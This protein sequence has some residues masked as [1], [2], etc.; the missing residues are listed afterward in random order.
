MADLT[1]YRIHD[2]ELSIRTA[3][4]LTNAFGPN[5][6]LHHIA[7]LTDAQLANGANPYIEG[8]PPLRL[9]RRSI[10]E[11]R[12]V[13]ENTCGLP[14]DPE[15][16][17]VVNNGRARASIPYDPNARLGYVWIVWGWAQEPFKLELVVIATT[18]EARTRYINHAR[19]LGVYDRVFDE[20]VYVDHLYAG[21]MFQAV[22]ESARR[23]GMIG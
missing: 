8:G 2:V 10:N 23:R 13:I 22:M 4:T 9:T 6:T 3:N 7:Q 20:Q 17:Q 5:V 19:A 1:K 14:D 16:E 21:G 18:G 11:I 15:G 12:E